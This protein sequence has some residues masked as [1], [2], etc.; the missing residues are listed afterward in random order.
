[1]IETYREEAGQYPAKLSHLG[2][3]FEQGLPAD[4]F[5]GQPYCYRSDENSYL[6]YSLGPNLTDEGGVHGLEHGSIWEEN[7]SDYVWCAGTADAMLNED[8]QL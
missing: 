2:D 6:L 4:P 1:M 3:R 7:K 8:G 5:S